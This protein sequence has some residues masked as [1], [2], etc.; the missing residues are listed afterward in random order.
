[1]SNKNK[2]TLETRETKLEKIKKKG[3]KKAFFTTVMSMG[4]LLGCT[5][6]LVGCGEAGPKGDTGAQG[7]QGAQGIQGVP[8]AA[9]ADGATWFTGT[10]VTGT[11]SGIEVTVANTKVGDLYFNTTTCDIYV[12]ASENTWNWVSNIKG[13]PGTPAA[14]PTVDI[15]DDGYWVINGVPTDQKAQGEAGV[16]PTITIVDGNW[17][18]NGE[19]TEVKAEAI[20][21]TKGADGNTWTVGTEYPATPNTG[22]MFLN[23]STWNVYQ[24]SGTEWSLK[25]NIKGADG[26]S[27][28]ESSST[29][30]ESIPSYWKTYLDAKIAEINAKTEAYG[31]S[32][33]AF[34]FIT[35]QHLQGSLDYSA[36]LINYITKNTSIKKVVMGGDIVQGSSSDNALLREY[37][38]LFSDE[39]LVMSIRGNHDVWGNATENSFYDIMLRPIIDK[40]DMFD[41]LYYSYDNEAQKIR[42]IF[43]DSTYAS[44]DGTSNLTS[45]EQIA[46]MKSKILELDSDWTTLIFHH[47][48]WTAGTGETIEINNDGQLMIDA[49]DSI[50]DEARCTI[51]GIY[52]GH[53]HRDYL[54]YSEK[55]YALVSTT[56]DCSSSGQSRYDVTNPT[57]TSGTT[58]EQTFDVVFLN[59]AANSF[60]TIRIGAG[61]DRSFNYS[62]K[63]TSGVVYDVEGVSL[64]KTTATTWIDGSTVKL[65]ANL[66]PTNAT[67]KQVTW[68]IISGETLGSIT[69]SGLSCTFTPGSSTG[70]V[71]VQVKTVDG[72]FTATCT[73]E[74]VEEAVSTDITSQFTWTPGIVQYASGNVSTKDTNWKYSN[75][76]DV[77]GY[78]SITFSHIQTTTAGTSLG[79]AF[80]NEN[81]TRISGESNT[82]ESYAP[83]RK[84]IDVP[85]G[86]KYFRT[87]WINTTNT[88]YDASI[89]E[90]ST[91]FYCYGNP[92]TADEDNS[93]DSDAGD[94]GNQE[95][96]YDVESVSLNKT[97]AT[98]WVN[99]NAVSLTANLTPTNATNKEVV[100]SIISGET[101]GSIESDGLSCAFTP[102]A[103]TGTVVVQVKTVDGEFTATCTIEIVEEA[104]STDITSQF[105]WT[106]GTTNYKTGGVLTSDT[107]W[108]Y[109][110][111]VDVS[112]YNSITFTHIQTPNAETSL[113]YAFYNASNTYISGASN[114]GS[115]Y[116]PVEK[117][118]NIPDGAKYFRV[119]WI[120]TTSANYDASIHEISTK[121]YCYG[122]PNESPEPVQSVSLNRNNATILIN[123][124]EVVLTANL[125][126][127]DATNKE[128]VWSIV[129][130]ETLGSIESDGLSCTFTS[131]ASAG[132][133]VVQ[134]KTVDGEFTATCTIQIVEEIVAANLTSQFTWTPGVV[135]YESGNVS[136]ND[137][138]W[139]YSNMVDVSAYTS[140]TFTHIQTTTAGTTLGYAFY[141]ENET[142]ISGESNTGE[143][144]APVE[145]TIEVPTGAKYFRTM[146]I[147][148][149]NTNYDA[150]IHEIGTKF[151]CSGNP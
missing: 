111:M 46:W 56:L 15:N 124:N 62:A 39:T 138:N 26:I 67:N 3:F 47:G 87:M 98:T 74:I 32:A 49:I 149:T 100:W 103:S 51:A 88:N 5:G 20:D 94:S 7:P 113:G 89:H 24:Y 13:E 130:G 81:Q 37:M 71:V 109:S 72:E 21:G 54:G 16:S 80:Y 84:T 126:P 142:Y 120:N 128:V 133:V 78:S 65:T 95:T 141:D 63:D 58:T 96:T 112:A 106:P 99:G 127:S 110:N 105:T 90:I 146:W 86:A 61:D 60:E 121:F 97:T 69:P 150:S 25:G 114:S 83:V 134:V 125:T 8:G 28:G 91:K 70:T 148:T 12:C 17:Y 52:S 117:T 102:G 151:S 132:T 6:M 53:A 36:S 137:T 108:V 48:I 14:A 33:D 55:G 144:Y 107:N 18:I 4:V 50:Y 122:N 10:E 76:V 115:S 135:K 59:P 38:E 1:M 29:D 139:L 75:M 119:M 45:D 118:I 57:R 44:S 93:G 147:N 129:S 34:I 66:T 79:Y 22:D 116:A 35:D 43:T 19:D 27:T 9:G 31:A 30:E 40:V 73:I 143:S 11:G 68:S 23:N 140:I 85:A 145:K 123:G 82:G 41:E 101:L 92:F 77:S 131:G 2:I 64:N 104:V 136:T 42:Y